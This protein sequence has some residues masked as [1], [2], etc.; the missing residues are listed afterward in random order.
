MFQDRE[1]AA[2]KLA[3]KLLGKIKGSN[4]L[5]IVLPKGAVKMGKIIAEY[6]SCSLGILVIKKIGAPL[7][8]ELAIGAIAP[9]TVF[10]N[11]DLISSL[12]LKQTD[13][14]QLKKEKEKE[15]RVLEK[16]LTGKKR[17]LNFKGKNVIL[18]DD[19]VATGATVLVAEK[20]IR[21]QGAKRITLAVPLIAADTYKELKK[22]FDETIVLKKVKNFQAVG[23]FYRNF[24]QVSNKE[25]V[26]LLK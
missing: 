1:E 11:E 25:V 3:L 18:I 2:K 12:F 14:N 15:R 23:Q 22:I 20:Y 10:W 17:K 21:K 6:L 7:N 26:N 8:P 13:L 9:S 19:G 24:P 16:I 5:I 4:C